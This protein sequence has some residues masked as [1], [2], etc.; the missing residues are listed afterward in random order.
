[1]LA[2]LV[3]W[4]FDGLERWFARGRAPAD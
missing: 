3:Q 1:V 2:L 4:F